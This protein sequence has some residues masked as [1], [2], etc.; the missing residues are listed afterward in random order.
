MT[1]FDQV[2]TKHTTRTA[3]STTTITEPPT[4]KAVEVTNAVIAQINTGYASSTAVTNG[5]KPNQ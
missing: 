1:P 2:T 5:T 4:M 3:K